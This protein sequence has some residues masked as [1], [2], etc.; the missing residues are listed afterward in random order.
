LHHLSSW[1]RRIAFTGLN[2]A[3]SLLIRAQI[4]AMMGRTPECMRV[5]VFEKKLTS[6]QVWNSAEIKPKTQG[7]RASTVRSN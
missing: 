3:I 5:S 7:K 6:R 1:P 2:H 4:R